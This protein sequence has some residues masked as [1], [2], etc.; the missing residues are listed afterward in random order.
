MRREGGGRNHVGFQDRANRPQCPR[1][2]AVWGAD[3]RHLGG[4]GDMACRPCASTLHFHERRRAWGGGSVG[5]RHE[6][7]FV[8]LRGGPGVLERFGG[9]RAAFAEVEVLC[10]WTCTL[11]EA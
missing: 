9:G 11:Q 4:I 10:H 3:F 6:L 1:K 2:S 8:G 7:L 5:S